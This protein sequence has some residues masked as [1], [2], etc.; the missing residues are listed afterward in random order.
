MVVVRKEKRESDKQS[1]SS[2]D[3]KTKSPR[4]KRGCSF[5]QSSSEPSYTD[6]AGLRRFVSDRSKIVPKLR[7]GLC[8]KHQRKVTK[9]I[10][11]ARHLALLPFVTR[12]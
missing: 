11:Y 12:I 9:Q 4:Q 10:K 2:N 5:C 7:S 1:L 8:S 6:T 3:G